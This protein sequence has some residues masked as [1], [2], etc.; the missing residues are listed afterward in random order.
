MTMDWFWPEGFYALAMLL[1]FA[2][3]AFGTFM[4]RQFLLSLPTDYEEAAR[5]D[6]ASQ[7]RLLWHVIVPLL[8]GP[9]AVVAAFSFIDYWNAFLWPLIIINDQAKAPLTFPTRGNIG[10]ASVPFT[11]AQQSAALQSGDRVL[12]MGIGSGINAMCL[13][14]AW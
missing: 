3:G 12:C 10:P 5:I 8:R 6:G 14:I 11:L 1:A 2:F 9:I 13:E 7:P 4:L